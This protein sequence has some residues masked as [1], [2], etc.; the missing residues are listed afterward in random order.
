MYFRLLI[1]VFFLVIASCSDHSLRTFVTPEG[2]LFFIRPALMQGTNGFVELD[3]TFKKKTSTLS[4][5]T[6]NLTVN[7]RKRFM[8]EPESITFHLD[9]NERSYTSNIQP[10]F[11]EV[12][13]KK[14]RFSFQMPAADFVTMV[15]A[16]KVRLRIADKMNEVTVMPTAD[17]SDRMRLCRNEILPLL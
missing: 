10:L 11:F 8:K 13:K 15:Q 6:V 1:P 5:V 3:F 7:S 2:P 4:D 12:G 16:S 9:E 14:S 17:F